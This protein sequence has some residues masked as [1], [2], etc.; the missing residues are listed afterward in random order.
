MKIG[1]TGTVSVGKSTLVKE[2]GKL[3]E[4]NNYNIFFTIFE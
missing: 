1:L 4:F 2:L 3:P